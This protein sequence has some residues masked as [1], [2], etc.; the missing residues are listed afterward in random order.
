MVVTDWTP[1]SS[2][3]DVVLAGVLLVPVEDAADEGRDE[4]DLGLGAGDGLVQAEEQGQVAVDALLLEDLG[5]LDAL[6]GGGD[7]D[8]D[9]S[10]GDA[11]LSYW[12]M[13]S[14]ACSMVASVS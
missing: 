11:G 5:G 4:G 3:P 12:A 1:G 8:E 6:P 10:R 7:L 2:A 13:M 14:R 9:A